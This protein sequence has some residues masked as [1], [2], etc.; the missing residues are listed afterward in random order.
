MHMLIFVCHVSFMIQCNAEHSYY[1][2]IF[3]NRL[4]RSIQA[5]EENLYL[6]Q[7]A[8]MNLIQ[9]LQHFHFSRS[10]FKI[11]NIPLTPYDCLALGCLMVKAESLKMVNFWNCNL[12]ELCVKYLSN[13]LKQNLK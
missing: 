7:T 9:K 3:M 6:L 1:Y 12:G 13:G 11:A 2:P 8:Y 4:L 5:L 10:D